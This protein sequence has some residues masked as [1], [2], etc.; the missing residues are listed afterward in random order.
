MWRP[1]GWYTF[2][3]TQRKQ[4]IVFICVYIILVLALGHYT[5]TSGYLNNVK[6]TSFSSSP[7]LSNP[8]QPLIYPPPKYERLYEWEK[9]LP[10]H[11]L[12]LPYP[13]GRTGR[14]VKFSN[15]IRLLGWNNVLNE[16]C[17]SLIQTSSANDDAN[18]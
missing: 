7:A 6:S 4:M 16:L 17:V 13:E 18:T 10:Q 9:N 2:P 15:Q 8:N 3:G 14:Y 1:F 11:N 5:Y 12:D